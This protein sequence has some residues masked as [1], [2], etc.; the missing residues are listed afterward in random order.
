MKMAKAVFMERDGIINRKLRGDCV[1]DW[2]EFSFLPGARKGMQLLKDAGFITVVVTNQRCISKGVASLEKLTEIHTRMISE[3]ARSG[4]SVDAV[5]FCP[6]GV[7]EGC[8]CRKP[9]PGMVTKALRDF[10]SRGIG[11][12]VK[13]S[14]FI[15]GGDRDMLAGKAAGLRTVK[16][17]EG[18][19][20]AD[21]RA[22]SLLQ[23]ARLICS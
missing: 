4:G 6:H 12:D 23:A 20:M 16:I 14:Y 18:H 3:I 7:D 9:A 5:Y 15:G 2:S 11:I 17:G 1:K 13:G 8:G 21:R 19:P 10:M 22:N